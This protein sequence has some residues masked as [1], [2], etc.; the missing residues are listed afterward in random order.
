MVL[1]TLFGRGFDSRHLHCEDN[2][3][4]SEIIQNPL[5]MRVFCF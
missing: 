1:V 3:I 5:K 2:S 4:L